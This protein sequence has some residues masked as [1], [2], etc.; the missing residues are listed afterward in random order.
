[1][2]GKKNLFHY[3]CVRIHSLFSEV[4][5]VTFQLS[6]IFVVICVMFLLVSLLLLKD[7]E[8]DFNINYMYEFLLTSLQ[9]RVA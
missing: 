5:K 2:L 7:N 4:Y 9:T 1:M 3:E 8:D 6:F